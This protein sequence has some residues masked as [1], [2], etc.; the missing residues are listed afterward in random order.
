M[1]PIDPTRAARRL[2][3]TM[4]GIWPELR[5][6]RVT[7]SWS[8]FTGYTFAHMPHVGTCEGMHYALGYSGSGVA[9]APWLGAKAAWQ[10]LGDARGETA[11][12]GTT[13]ATRPFHGGGAPHFLRAADLWY[14]HVVDPRQNRAAARDSRASAVVPEP[15]QS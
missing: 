11:Y 10:A 5:A 7:H 3:A 12:S 8:G 6:T 4:T 9:L 14:R 2:H 15:R 13:L 1:V